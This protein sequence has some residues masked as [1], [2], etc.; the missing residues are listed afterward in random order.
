MKK[1]TIL[2]LMLTALTSSYGQIAVNESF[3]SNDFP[4]NWTNTGGASFYSSTNLACSGNKSAVSN[5]YSSWWGDSTN[6]VLNSPIY[7]SDGTAIE[8]SLSY[9]AT[10]YIG[11]DVTPSSDYSLSIKYSTDNG[12]TWNTKHTIDSTNNS[13]TDDCGAL[14]LNFQ[15]GEIP[16]GNV[17]FRFEYQL[18]NLNSDINVYLDNISI[19]Q[20]LSTPPCPTNIIYNPNVANCGNLGGSINW[21]SNSLTT[22]YNVTVGTTPNGSDVYSGNIFTNSLNLDTTNAATTYYVKVIGINSIGSSTSCTETTF[23]TTQGICYCESVPTSID[24]DGI[25]SVQIGETLLTQGTIS[26][27]DHTSTPVNVN[28]GIATPISIVFHT[29]YTYNTN[30]WVDLNSNG[31]FE[32]SELLYQGESLNNNPT[33]LFAN[34]TL[35]V[36]LAN[37][38][39]RMRIGT[40]DS[41]Q[42]IPDPCYSGSYG[43][44]LDYTLNVLDVPSCL[45]PTE[46]SATNITNNSAN[47]SWTST[48][49][50]FDIQYGVT[51]F[52]LGQGTI[53]DNVSNNYTLNNITSDTN[54]SYYVRTVCDNDESI[55]SGPYNFLTGYCAS[56]PTNIDTN[57]ITNVTINNQSESLSF[58]TA[59]Y[60]INNSS[61]NFNVVAGEQNT[62]ALSLETGI[63]DPYWGETGYSYGI[64]VWVDLNNDL[65]FDENEIIFN[66]ISEDEVST[67]IVNGNFTIPSNTP[68][69]SYKMRIVGLDDEDAAP[70]PCFSDGYG[71]SVDYTLNVS[72]SLSNDTQELKSLQ[73]YPNPTSNFV[74]ISNDTSISSIELFDINGRKLYSEILSSKEVQI[75][76]EAYASGTYLVKVSSEGKQ[77]IKKIIKK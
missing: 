69:G 26:Y 25:A 63:N 57:G 33:T 8:L 67:S 9:K 42:L 66:A 58:T 32:P 16:S 29:G 61:T 46:L 19:S 77:S 70:N 60:Y 15:A 31:N 74:T 3:E 36:T 52:T 43:V 10:N 71:C 28:K 7:T 34:I 51:G 49:S 6:S 53:I 1:F 59:P 68:A 22:S 64:N 47:L 72:N 76:L 24:N 11:E 44:T 55:W 75:N 45:P 50:T 35:P 21:D 4:I 65:I 14:N 73:I 38:N 17:Q 23:T 54:Y 12:V 39:Y 18:I 56:Q 5:I 40:A 37:G 27:F 48:S 2:S 41:G 30:I 20:S 62:I 13:S